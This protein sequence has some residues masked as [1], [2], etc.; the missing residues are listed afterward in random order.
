MVC[1]GGPGADTHDVDCPG[2]KPT[3]RTALEVMTSGSGSRCVGSQHFSL[4]RSRGHYACRGVGFKGRCYYMPVVNFFQARLMYWFVHM[5]CACN[6]MNALFGRVGKCTPSVN[7]RAV[8]D[9]LYPLAMTLA[10]WV[11]RHAPIPYLDVY[12]GMSGRKFAKYKRAEIQLIRQGRLATKR[13]SEIEMFVKIEGILFTDAKRN[14]DCRA[15]QFR[16]PEYVLQLASHIK[17]AE[18]KLYEVTD[19]P[20]FGPGRL[21][22]KNLNP[23]QRAQELHKKWLGT[24]GHVL[25][26]DASR[27]DAH[28]TYEMLHDVEHPFWKATCLGPQIHELLKW[29][30]HNRGKF[31]A[32]EY[33]QWYSVRGGRMSGDANTAAGNCIIMACLLAAF[34]QSRGVRFSFLCDG[35][36]SVFFHEGREITDI[37]VV[38]FFR[39]FGFTMK[40]ENRPRM[41][42][43]INFCQSKPVCIDGDWT[44]IRNPYKIL[45]KLGVSP[46]LRNP[47]GRAKYIRTVALGE[48]SLVRGCPVLQ[49]FLKRVV[50]VCTAAM[51]MRQK[52]RGLI[53]K[54]AMGHYYRL[55]QFIPG[56]WKDGRV[57]PV[58]P[59][60]RKSFQIAW[61]IGVEEQIRLE[62]IVERWVFDLARTLEGGGIDVPKWMPPVFLPERW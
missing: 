23:R 21:F 7:W 11:G 46:K 15:I 61:G 48:L 52:N 31:K 37:E 32:G 6:H 58:T 53:H 17:V 22:A 49:A 40:I 18:H 55:S 16:R 47:T 50:D 45:S 27:F 36:D 2:G 26:L 14:P 56:D 12:K 60:T 3:K 8:K 28:V 42:E 20:G 59:S 34:G 5:P 24:P 35:D 54:E 43:E 29:Q 62:S 33:E 41:F 51:T 44:M 30:L 19:V 1:T 38:T 13:Q 25:E 9:Y 4:H 57:Q 39:Q 10:T